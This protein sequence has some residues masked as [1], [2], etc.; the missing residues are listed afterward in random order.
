MM[1]VTIRHK[2][3][4]AAF[5]ALVISVALWSS[6]LAAAG[7]CA[8]GADVCLIVNTAADNVQR[9]GTLSLREALLV[10][11]G[12]LDVDEL[13]GPEQL[14]VHVVGPLRFAG[15][16]EVNFDAELSG[17][18]IY[19]LPPGLGGGDTPPMNQAPKPRNNE[20]IALADS[21]PPGLGGGDTP[22]AWSSLPPGLGG[23]DTPP[24]FAGAS[25]I[26]GMIKDGT[27]VRG[28]VTLDGSKLGTVYSGLWNDGPGTL[29][30][31]HFQNF[32]GHAVEIEKH[33]VGLVDYSAVTF[34]NNAVDVAIV[35]N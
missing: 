1:L 14:Q 13:T 30:G 25:V 7:P 35:N 29:R 19:V 21:L 9:D 15:V 24:A 20:L 11:N 31:L 22:P 4:L 17:Q 10:A 8:P 16:V 34:A 18:T 28:Q 23:G 32:A 6:S 12:R 33:V 2:A 3:C 5:A 26:G 27:L